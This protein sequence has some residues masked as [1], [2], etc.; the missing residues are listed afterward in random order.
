MANEVVSIEP[1]N[2]KVFKHLKFNLTMNYLNRGYNR[3]KAAIQ[4]HKLLTILLIIL[5]LGL[6]VSAGIIIFVYQI[7]IFEDIQNIIEPM[8]QANFDADSIQ[9]G[10]PFIED[11]GLIYQNYRSLTNNLI[12][13]GIWLIALFLIGNGIIWVLAQ[14]LFKPTLKL[15]NLV[16]RWLKYLSAAAVIIGP[17][18]LISYF[19][20]KTMITFGL[21]VGRF[22]STAKILSY[23]F[24][25]VYFIFALTLPHLDS[26]S[27]K[28]FLKR[29]LRSFQEIPK[30]VPV[31][32]IN[33]GLILGS[34]GLIYYL[35]NYWQSFPLTILAAVLFV[36]V[37]ALSK[38]FWIGSLKEIVYDRNE[39]KREEKQTN[40]KNN[41]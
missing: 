1:Q 11:I 33:V 14:Q 23:I 39:A 4:K 15:K 22:S 13:F 19:L 25:L 5:Q 20:L 24:L 9:E 18:F 41:P 7:K 32:I 27:W 31:L 38:L 28:T 16:Q 30:M 29:F 17:F 34:L 2:R 26:S 35:M 10:N 3:T 12:N 40:E 8:S 36:L 6:I 37:M 21:D